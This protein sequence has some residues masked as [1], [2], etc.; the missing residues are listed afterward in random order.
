[1]KRAT[2]IATL[3]TLV[4]GLVGYVLLFPRYGRAARP[5]SDLPDRSAS[6]AIWRDRNVAV[7]R[8]GERILE[9]VAD[10]PTPFAPHHAEPLLQAA[11]MAQR[12]DVALIIVL[13]DATVSECSSADPQFVADTRGRVEE[14]LLNRSEWPVVVGATMPIGGFSSR[15]ARARRVGGVQIVERPNFVRL[16]RGGGRYLVFLKA[17]RNGPPVAGFGYGNAFEIRGARLVT[18]SV[19]DRGSW[20]QSADAE[21]TLTLV[22]MLGARPAVTAAAWTPPPGLAP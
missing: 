13:D 8:G 9:V 6:R 14:V 19:P 16:P 18:M 4:L 11:V 7:P 5:P 10:T 1:M 15:L 22:R 20:R 12:A 2:F 21:R 17:T 3:T